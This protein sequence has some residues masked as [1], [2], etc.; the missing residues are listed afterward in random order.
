MSP[1]LTT[2]FTLVGAI[3]AGLPLLWLTAPPPAQ[4]Q[5]TLPTDAP[6]QRQVHASIYFSGKPDKITLYHEAQEI[7]T[8]TQPVSQQHF[9]LKL[10]VGDTIEMEYEVQWPENT[11]GMKG[12]T[13]HLEPEGQEPRTETMWTMPEE[14][15]LNDIFYFRW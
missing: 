6:H 2:T 3:A 11:P 12:F 13:L 4:P 10:P 7:A 9:M 5:E 14:S 8:F 1:T 15:Q